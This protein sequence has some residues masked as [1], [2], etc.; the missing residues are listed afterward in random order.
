PRVFST[1]LVILGVGLIIGGLLFLFYR[2]ILLFTEDLDMMERRLRELI[3]SLEGGV[4]SWFGPGWI[5]EFDSLEDR[6]FSLLRDNLASLT[7]GLAGAASVVTS[8]F[9][10]P[11]YLFL[12]L[13]FRNF[14]QEFLLQLVGRGNDVR[15]QRA[16]RIFTRVGEVVQYYIVGVGLVILILATL[17]SSMLW[18]LGVRHAIFFGVFA[19]MLNIIPFIG[20]L[21]GSI[22][23]ILYALVTMDSWIYPIII[24]AGFYLVQ[25]LEGNLLTPVIVGSRVSMNALVTLVLLLIGA[26]I[27][28]LAGMILFIPLGAIL[29]V[30]FDEIESL[31]PF[32]FLLG[33]VPSEMQSS[34]GP[35]ARRINL[36]GRS[37]RDSDS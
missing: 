27:W 18:L 20:P 5:G 29:K 19:G 37:V 35:L 7:Q 32:G 13:M 3:G 10:I 34:K 1:A 31:Q 28:G 12:I 6:L 8:A 11:V 2:Q 17:Y 33:R 36:L 30:V 4:S 15:L 16:T 26:K 25:L 24:I 9:L 21:F 14:L 23:P 22:L